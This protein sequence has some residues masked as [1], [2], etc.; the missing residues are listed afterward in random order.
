MAGSD[1]LM[2]GGACERAREWASLRL[3]DELSVLEE[4]ILERHLDF[5]DACR[6]FEEGMR[7]S[8]ARIRSTPLETPTRR[9]PVPARTGVVT[10]YRKRT[11]LVA[12]AALAIGALVGSLVERPGQP[13]PS[14]SPSQVSFLSRDANNLRDFSRTRLMTPL[15][16]PAAPRNPPEGVI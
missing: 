5:C 7:L 1:P 16:A 3:D 6:R 13:V 14:E 8:T 2:M 10:Q 11:A 4:E 9:V 15:P 12:A